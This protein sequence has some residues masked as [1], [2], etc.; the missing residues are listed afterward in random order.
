MPTI[1][2]VA[3]QAGVSLGTVSR[4]INDAGNIMP[5][6]REK[7]ERAIK[8]L[9]YVPSASAQSLRSKRT[10][11]LAMV[12]PTI[13]NPHWQALVR[14]V[15]D[16]A[17]RRNYAV[18][19]GNTDDDPEKQRRYV[20]LAVRQNVAGMFIAPCTAE[21]TDIEALQTRNIPTVLVNRRVD[22]WQTDGVFCDNISGAYALVDHLIKLGHEH[23]AVI[24]GPEHLSTMRE[25][26]YGYRLAF[27]KNN[28]PIDPELARCG[29]MQ[30]AFGKQFANQL[31]DQDEPPT[32]FFTT[33]DDLS[34]GVIDALGK[35]RL[36]IPHDIALVTFGGHAWPAFRFLTHVLE[37]AYDMGMNAVELLFNRLEG[38]EE[39]TSR[40]VVL[41]TRLVVRYSCGSQ[42]CDQRDASPMLLLNDDAHPSDV[43][44]EPLREGELFHQDKVEQSRDDLA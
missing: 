31:L 25:R 19:L 17:H 34:D 12:V 7:V 43:L 35:R 3:K 44:V 26:L 16:A 41:P 23:I 4:V 14:G 15:E 28:L 38:S 8:D 2:D 24:S 9:G 33:T 42:L 1:S 18:F 5:D 32:A 37:P 13:R 30:P 6:T 20:D 29:P 39:S 36:R 10:R 27:S 40:Q 22:S 21:S 11:W